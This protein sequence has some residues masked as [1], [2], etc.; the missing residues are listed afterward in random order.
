MQASRCQL[1]NRKDGYIRTI[2]EDGFNGI[3]DITWGED[4]KM[5]RDKLV[6]GKLS[7]GMLFRSKKIVFPKIGSAEK[8][9]GKHCCI[10][11]TTAG[12]SKVF[13]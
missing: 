7:E 5:T 1:G 9:R 3:A 13:A 8:N 12:L 4:T 10:G 6:D 11:H 2:Q